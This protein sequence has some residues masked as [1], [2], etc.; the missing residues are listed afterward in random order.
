VTFEV[1]DTKRQVCDLESLQT[2]SVRQP[3]SGQCRGARLGLQPICASTAHFRLFLD[4]SL[5]ILDGRNAAVPFRPQ[6]ETFSAGGQPE[7]VVNLTVR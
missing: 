2:A 4:T 3:L 6:F 1:E 7:I 5:E